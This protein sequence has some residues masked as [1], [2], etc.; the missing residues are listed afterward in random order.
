LPHHSLPIT[1]LRSQR[2]LLI[3]L[4]KFYRP[5]ELGPPEEVCDL[6]KALDTITRGVSFHIT[7][8]PADIPLSELNQLCQNGLDEL[9]RVLHEYVM[10]RVREEQ[11]LWHSILLLLDDQIVRFELWNTEVEEEVEEVDD[12]FPSRQEEF[13][14]DRAV[15]GETPKVLWLV[16]DALTQIHRLSSNVADCISNIIHM[17]EG[18]RDTAGRYVNFERF[19]FI[20]S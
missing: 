15:P 5:E 19:S 3:N 13:E 4:D 2:L 11:D 16:R 20:P 9:H 8:M 6:L 12:R 18:M 10:Q 17:L 1:A 14:L 7:A